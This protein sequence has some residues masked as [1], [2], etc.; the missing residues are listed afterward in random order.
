MHLLKQFR[1]KNRN[2]P[3]FFSEIAEVL[4]ERDTHPLIGN[5][6][7]QQRNRC[8]TVIRNAKSSFYVTALSASKGNPVW[9]TVKSLSHNPISIISVMHSVNT[10]FHL[11][12]YLKML[13]F[14]LLSLIIV[15]LAGQT[16]WA[17]RP[18][19]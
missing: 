13:D 5:I 8:L 2:N 14:L 19:L 1:V 11:V 18:F 17:L 4:Y 3:C 16:N 15:H 7:R 6:F 10:L 12:I 9:K